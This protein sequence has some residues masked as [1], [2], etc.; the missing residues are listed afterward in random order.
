MTRHS[1]LDFWLPVAVSITGSIGALMLTRA[2]F[3]R[4]SKQ[5]EACG[6]TNDCESPLGCYDGICVPRK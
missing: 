6:T 4:R 5:N 1:N 2:L 3:H